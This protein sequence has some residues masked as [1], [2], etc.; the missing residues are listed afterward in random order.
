MSTLRLDKYLA[1]MKIGTRSEVKSY[2]KKRM[3]LVNGSVVVLPQQ[4]VNLEN[5][6]I[7][8]QGKEITY[9]KYEYYMLHK[10]A[11]FVSATKDNVNE[12]VVSLIPSLKDIFPV[13]RLDKDTEGLLLLTNDGEL[14]HNLLSPKKHVQKTYFARIEGHVMKEDIECFLQGIDIGDATKTLPAHLCILES[15]EISEV[16]ITICEGRFHQIKRMFQAINKNVI[17]LKRISM[18]DLILDKDLPIG[19]YRKLT[20]KEVEKLRKGNEK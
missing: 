9:T 8:F 4:K 13:G 17:Y 20:S 18:G 12:T 16:H 2:I 5:D 15:G 19:E 1:D 3:V 6:A 11:G 7:L 14:A 10:P